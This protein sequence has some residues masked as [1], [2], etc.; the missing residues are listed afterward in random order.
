MR[1]SNV[2]LVLFLLSATGC[3]G[4]DGSDPGSANSSGTAGPATIFADATVQ[5]PSSRFRT[6]VLSGTDHFL[7]AQYREDG[8]AM[9]AGV[10][11]HGGWHY[12]PA[13][14][15]FSAVAPATIAFLHAHDF[16]RTVL[17]ADTRYQVGGGIAV[18]EPMV[19]TDAAGGTIRMTVDADDRPTLL[20][21]PDHRGGGRVQVRPLDWIDRDGM[22]LFR[23]LEITQGDQVY[24][25]QFD[26]IVIDLAPMQSVLAGTALS[27]D[28]IELQRLH[29]L[30]QLAHLAADAT[31]F[32]AHFADPITEISRG[33]ANAVSRHDARVRFQRYFDATTF[34]QWRDVTAPRLML[35]PQSGHA[36]KIVEKE[37]LLASAA[38]APMRFAW[39]ES[40]NKDADGAWRLSVIVSTQ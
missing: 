22:A 13:A 21:Y 31:L 16:H 24:R 23:Q 6:V 28:G 9:Y 5:G 33:R 34:H 18:D 35:H 4:A 10:D 2:C 29:H 3:W 8:T 11:A 36:E 32:T 7:F 26:R 20:D 17:A 30:D 14:S 27:A 1:P 37:V 39:L 19:L 12:D 15:R 38:D 40:W 25:Y